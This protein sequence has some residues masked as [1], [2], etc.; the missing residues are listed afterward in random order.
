ML[1]QIEQSRLSLAEMLEYQ[2]L[3]ADNWLAKPV[4]CLPYRPK[5]KIKPCKNADDV[6]RR[7]EELEK[8]ARQ[9]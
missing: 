4:Y 7:L 2:E 8:K 6:A 1:N 9:C 5:I 3:I